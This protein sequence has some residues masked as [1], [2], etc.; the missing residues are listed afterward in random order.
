MTS[1]ELFWILM[2][3]FLSLSAQHWLLYYNLAEQVA[4]E[5]KPIIQEVK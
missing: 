5:L 3:F 4:A 1:R 2:I